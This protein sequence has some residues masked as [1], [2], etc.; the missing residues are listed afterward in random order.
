VK[1]Y[2]EYDQYRYKNAVTFFF[3]K[4]VAVQAKSPA[5][6]LLLNGKSTRFSLFGITVGMK[7]ETAFKKLQKAGFKR[8]GSYGNY[9]YWKGSNYR[10]V[11]LEVDDKVKS[12]RYGAW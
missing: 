8:N 3:P 5:S 10:Q 2:A 7:K 11:D 1:Q 12:I 4:P 6:I 9:Y